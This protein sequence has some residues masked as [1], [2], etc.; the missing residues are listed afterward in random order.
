MRKVKSNTGRRVKRFFCLKERERRMTE[1][2][3][4]ASDTSS[5]QETKELQIHYP[6]QFTLRVQIS[7]PDFTISRQLNSR[8][9]PKGLRSSWSKNRHTYRQAFPDIVQNYGAHRKPSSISFAL[10]ILALS[11]STQCHGHDTRR[12]ELEADLMIPESS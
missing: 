4:P 1:S 9:K 2:G 3:Y 7:P 12:R 10:S 5:Q 11:P 8:K 6:K